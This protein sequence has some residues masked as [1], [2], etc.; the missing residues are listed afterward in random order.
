MSQ[1]TDTQASEPHEPITLKDVLHAV[2]M[3]P[4]E[5]VGLF[6]LPDIPRPRLWPSKAVVPPVPVQ[7]DLEDLSAPAIIIY[8]DSPVEAVESPGLSRMIAVGFGTVIAI[9]IGYLAQSIMTHQHDGFI[10]ALLYGLAAF[11]WLGLLMF[12]IA[13]PDGGLLRR[14]PR[15]AGGGAARP[16]ASASPGFVMVTIRVSLVGLALVLSIVTYIFT[17]DNTFT[18]TGLV[19]WVLSVL[20]WL[21]V[22]A[23]R[24]PVELLDDFV[25]WLK[26]IPGKLPSLPQVRLIPLLAFLLILGAAIFFRFYRLNTIPIEMTSD[27]VEKLLDA[28]DVASGIYHVFFTRNAGRE[29]IQF[30][31]VA[32]AG[33]LF[34]T[35]MSFLTLKLVSALE[36]VTLIPVIILLGR[37]VVDRETGFL[38]A[39]LVAISWWHTTL[40]RLALRI[41]LTPLVFTLVLITLIRGIR[42]GS[43]R[44]WVWAGIWMGVG[45]YAYQAMRVTPLVA[46]VALLASILGPIVSAVRAHYANS[47]DAPYRRTV[48][49]NITG[50]QVLNLALAGLVALAIFVPML[51]VWHDYPGELWNRVINRTTSSE[52]AIEGSASA[53]LFQNYIDA[54]RMFNLRGDGAW[55][56]ALP[57][58]PMLDLITGGLLVMGVLAWLVRLRIRRD[59]VDAFVILA[60]MIMLLPS[61]LAL[62]FPIENP[63]ATRASAVI[64]VVFLLAAWPL[65]LIHQRWKAVLTHIRGNAL[66]VA[67]LAVLLV[68]SALANY[69][70]YFIKYADSYR[71]SALNPS[72]VAHA[73]RE[74]IGPDASLDGVWLQGWPY[75]QDYRAIGIEAG[76]ISFDNAIVDVP[77]LITYL[78][79]S[80]DAFT[81]RPLVFIVHPDDYEALV[82]L[83]EHFPEGEARYYVSPTEGRGFYL[84]IVLSN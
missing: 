84:Y 71:R 37:E 29:A 59:P 2:F 22:A 74:V 1:H 3:P 64:P 32:L 62:A 79:M 75:W 14:G 13:P 41:A 17:A 6:T 65:S 73:V 68:G 54:L 39:A 72:E 44:A 19:A 31:L 55:I 10:G 4:Q 46:L 49:V 81:I 48:A 57:G 56:S 8:E 77:A 33:R 11:I 28:N 5:D 45:V 43:R 21:V 34:G 50:R 70:T 20:I 26:R 40:G 23:E 78:D 52:R 51:R 58:A 15:V 24:S 83:G 42:T 80:P 76:D 67:L 82:I 27:H 25:N 69:Q 38:A 47:P 18:S 7:P 35:G 9:L 36:A 12:E 30:Y 61:A 66:A 53:V 60:G 16:L 63:S